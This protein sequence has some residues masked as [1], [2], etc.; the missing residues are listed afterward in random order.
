MA[1][2]TLTVH[3]DDG[4]RAIEF[5][6]FDLDLLEVSDSR[7]RMDELKQIAKAL[8]LSEDAT[9]DQIVAELGKRVALPDLAKAL[10]IDGDIS[11]RDTLVSKVKE[12]L[13][14]A[15]EGDTLKEAAE[16]AG[17][18]LVE[19]DRLKTLEEKA[20]AGQKALDKLVEQDFEQAY[21]KAKR[22]GKL[23][24][25]D[26]TKSEWKELYDAAPELT[27]KRLGKLPKIVN[28]EPS[29]SGEGRGD[30]PENQDADRAEL[31]RQAK[32]YA[33]DKGVT[34]SEALRIVS[35]ERKAS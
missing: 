6:D 25:K 1:R 10:G 24:T 19:S 31:D 15:P 11:D 29:G 18:K 9:A 23:D 28:T 13:E 26:E 2:V 16:A 21:D 7:A 14:K 35:A 5:D 32:D 3:T 33:R 30:V 20:D 17:F 4:P 34:Y 22:D 8:G 27:L 12:Q